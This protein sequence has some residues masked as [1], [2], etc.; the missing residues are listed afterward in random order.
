[1]D[2]ECQTTVPILYGEIKILLLIN[3]STIFKMVLG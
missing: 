2:A 3:I 1:M